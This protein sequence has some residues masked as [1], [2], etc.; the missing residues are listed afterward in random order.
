MRW[1]VRSFDVWLSRRLKVFELN[2]DSDC[3]L[4][5]QVS[6]SRRP[7]YLK[8]CQIERGELVLMLHLCNDRVPHFIAST[9][10]LAWAKTTQR[11]MLNSF[12]LVAHYLVKHPELQPVRAIG[13]VTILLDASGHQGGVRLVERLGFTVIPYASSLGS[14]GE[15]WENFYSYLL[16]WAYQ[17]A[18][19]GYRPPLKLKR[20]EFWISAAEFIRRFGNEQLQLS[21]VHSL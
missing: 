1:L 19:L 13:G 6:R 5:L 21:T 4:R 14:F 8:D 12:G 2:Q 15:F 9:P 20:Q 3:I 11:L 10:D 17:P 18:S 7:L 16:I